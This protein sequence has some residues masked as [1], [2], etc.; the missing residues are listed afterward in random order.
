[1]ENRLLELL[2]QNP[3]TNF[4]RKQL[5]EV[6]VPGVKVLDRTIDVHIK[7]IRKK[8]PHLQE[9]IE[10]VRGIGYRFIPNPATSEL[11][12]PTPRSTMSLSS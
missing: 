4:S 9:C 7:S 1:M 8:L 5:L 11:I 3:G 12:N 6:L 2:R 10:T